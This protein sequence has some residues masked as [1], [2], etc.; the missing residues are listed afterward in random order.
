MF[1]PK[2]KDVRDSLHPNM[3]DKGPM[4]IAAQSYNGKRMSS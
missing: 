2:L 3:L 1:N 4:R